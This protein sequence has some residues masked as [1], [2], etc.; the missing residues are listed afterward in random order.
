MHLQSIVRLIL[1]HIIMVSLISTFYTCAFF[2]LWL[3]SA[4]IQLWILKVLRNVLIINN[5]GLIK[6]L[7]MIR[8]NMLWHFATKHPNSARQII[9]SSQDYMV[10]TVLY[11]QHTK[12]KN[13]TD[14]PPNCTTNKVSV[15]NETLTDLLLTQKQNKCQCWV[16]KS[17][18]NSKQR[19]PDVLIFYTYKELFSSSANVTDV[20]PILSLTLQNISVMAVI[21]HNSVCHPRS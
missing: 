5:I 4:K 1:N 10:Y 11:K 19:N 17:I 3:F 12:N 13:W 14:T 6:V 2:F 9:V 20:S 21:K 15:T 18:N 7:Y 16:Y 8:S